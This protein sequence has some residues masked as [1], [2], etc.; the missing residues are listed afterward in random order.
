LVSGATSVMTSGRGFLDG[1]VSGATSVTTSG[2]G[3]LDGAVSGATSV[4]TSGRGF[5]YGPVSGAISVTTSGF[6]FLDGSG[7][8]LFVVMDAVSFEDRGATGKK[9]DG[10]EAAFFRSL[11]GRSA[12]AE[13]FDER[14]G[15]TR[16]RSSRPGSPP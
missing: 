16:E 8:G 14:A 2:R 7:S 5:L 15:R 6:G 11:C 1:A 3:F 12:R 9:V 13:S 4:T 10:R